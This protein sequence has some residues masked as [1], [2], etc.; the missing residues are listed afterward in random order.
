MLIF[1]KILR[2]YLMDG[3]LF[4]LNQKELPKNQNGVSLCYF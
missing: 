1:R 4:E 2:A 3:H